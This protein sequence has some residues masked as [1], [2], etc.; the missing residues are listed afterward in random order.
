MTQF[1]ISP[2]PHRRSKVSVKSLMYGRIVALL[3]V[4]AASLTLFGAL[5]IVNILAA[6]LGAVGIEF[7]I[8]T[9][10]KQ[11]LTIA[12]GNAAYLG[13]LLAL[14]CPPSLP[15]WMIFVGGAFAV[16]VGKH[17][18]GGLGSYIFHPTLAAWVFLNLAWTQDMLPGSVPI[19]SGFSDL[20][21]ENGAGFLTDVSPILII[22]TG[23]VLI[24]RKYIEWRI[25][26]SYFL[27][28]VVLGLVLGDPLSYIVQGTFLL[29][30]F[31][32]ATETATSPVTKN[33]R[34]VYGILCGLLTVLYGY[35]SGNYVWGTLYAILL[36]NAVGPFIEMKTLPKPLGGVVNE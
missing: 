23:L 16:G 9:V 14:I 8:Q 7:V 30:V 32:I 20:L 29:G 1:T 28:T 6:I 15:A 36:S 25:P 21:Y 11:K 3:I 2:P 24:A 33:G 27:T 18:F 22:L 10:L 13:L 34:I 31:F 5:A 35:F 17:A 19:A 12:D 4:G 26:L